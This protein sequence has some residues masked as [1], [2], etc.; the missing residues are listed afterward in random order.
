[1]RPFVWLWA[2]LFSGLTSSLAPFVGG[3]SRQA[4]TPSHCCAALRIAR[5]R[6][7]LMKTDKQA[8]TQRTDKAPEQ[9]KEGLN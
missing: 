2:G 7:S 1:M 3:S 5:R 6:F 4:L 8:H 9:S